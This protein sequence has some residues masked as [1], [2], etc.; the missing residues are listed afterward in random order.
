MFIAS[1]ERAYNLHSAFF[2][3]RKFILW[4][5]ILRYWIYECSRYTFF[6]AD[7]ECDRRDQA[8]GFLYMAVR[9][10]L[11]KGGERF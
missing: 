11:A 2:M 7:A 4:I 9:Q 3:G 8:Y 6:L 1:A 10:E 5:Y